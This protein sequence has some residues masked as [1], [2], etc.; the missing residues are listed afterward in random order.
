MSD[1]LTGAK[2]EPAKLTLSVAESDTDADPSALFTALIALKE[3]RALLQL[4]TPLR[5]WS[6]LLLTDLIIT[7]D[8]K[9]P[10]G[11]TG[12]LTLQETASIFTPVSSTGSTTVSGS[13]ANNTSTASNHGT[14]SPQPTTTA[15]VITIL[16]NGVPVS[17]SP[18][19]V[20]IT[21][22]K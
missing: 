3:S 4:I 18:S 7:R 17:V 16:N 15:H 6:N 8:D 20:K 5:T 14:A 9:T 21:V 22:L 13:S 11:W 1:I 2:N 19:G 12:T 10:F